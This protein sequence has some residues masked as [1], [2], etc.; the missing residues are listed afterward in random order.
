MNAAVR[1]ER[2]DESGE[3]WVVS[4]DGAE[5]GFVTKCKRTKGENHPWKAFRGF[6]FAAEYLGSFYS[7][8]GGRNG[9][10]KAVLG[11]KG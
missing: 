7:G 11:L 8:E 5:V 6:G 3:L 2:Q 10:I 9:A 4:R 1:L